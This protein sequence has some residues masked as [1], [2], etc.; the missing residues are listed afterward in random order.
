MDRFSCFVLDL[1]HGTTQRVKQT[2]ER[3]KAVA[4]EVGRAEQAL[5]RPFALAV[6]C[7]Q[8][9]G[10]GALIALVAQLRAKNDAGALLLVGFE[11]SLR[12]LESLLH[13]GVTD[14]VGSGFSDDELLARAH[15][16]L[17]LMP[18]SSALPL[19]WLQEDDVVRMTR[20]AR[21]RGLLARLPAA[22]ASRS[23]VVLIG[24]PGC[25]K[26][27]CINA[28]LKLC[29]PRSTLEL[30]LQRDGRDHVEQILRRAVDGPHL[31]QH[32][33]LVVFDAHLL[34]PVGRALV[35]DLME[36]FPRSEGPRVLLSVTALPQLDGL[37]DRML[38]QIDVPATL[39]FSMPPLRERREDIVHLALY[40]TS[41]ASGATARQPVALSPAAARRLLLHRWPGNLRELKS[42]IARAL[43]L[44][45]GPL[46]RASD[47]VFDES[48]SRY[49][50]EQS[51]QSAKIDVMT[52][53]E[54]DFLEQ[55]LAACDGNIGKAARL[56]RKNRR[57]LFELI[58]KHEIDVERYRPNEPRI[59][60]REPAAVYQ[61]NG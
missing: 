26:R 49:V 11:L 58:R 43:Q 33:Q 51:L 36:Q 23:H 6:V 22:A 14:F 53:F 57:A 20:N 61:L 56:A 30:D 31:T 40:M 4:L 39:R 28:L 37:P 15:R 7:G 16:C 35:A 32:E 8:G 19:E 44:A 21:L 50:G 17:G 25:G 46:L 48:S 10:S 1:H 59:G 27:S 9:Q 24:E 29:G 52:S 55:L 42:V 45:S 3:D 34:S 41:R 38:R 54:R 47:I 13:V 18:S 12:D 2:L 60:A 5:V